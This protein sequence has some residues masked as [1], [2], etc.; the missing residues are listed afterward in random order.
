MRTNLAAF[1]LAAFLE[2]AGVIGGS[3]AV[4]LSVSADYVLLGAG[5]LLMVTVLRHRIRS[6]AKRT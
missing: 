2:I 4:L 5:V 1:G 3:A 6:T